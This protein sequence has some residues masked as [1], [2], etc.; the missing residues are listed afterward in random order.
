MR[1]KKFVYVAL[2]LFGLVSCVDDKYS[3]DNLDPTMELD[4]NVVGPLGYS[5]LKIVDVLNADSLGD[6]EIINQSQNLK[7]RFL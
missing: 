5:S 4:A 1:I 3:F 2:I 6:L 7:S